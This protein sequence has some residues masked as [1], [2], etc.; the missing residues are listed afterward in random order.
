MVT[1]LDKLVEVVMVAI[2]VP[3]FVQYIVIILLYYTYIVI[4]YFLILNDMMQSFTFILQYF[5]HFNICIWSHLSTST[6][7][8]L[9]G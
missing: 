9:Y 8:Y 2:A 3:Y 4:I 6:Y 5:F 1:V 7:P